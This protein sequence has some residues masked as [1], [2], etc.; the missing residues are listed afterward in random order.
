MKN[1]VFVTGHLTGGGSER[2]LT[3]IANSML[4]QGLEVSIITFEDINESYDNSCK[5]YKLEFSNDF[6]QIF[7][8]RKLIKK[9]KAEVVIAF[10]YYVAIKTVFATRGMECKVIVSERNDPNMLNSLLKKK[11]RNL[12]YLCADILVCQTDDAKKCFSKKTQNHTVVIP[13][14]IK[15]DLPVWG[16]SYSNKKII[17]FC[18]LEKQKNIPLL[19]RAF[20]EVHKKHPDY[21]LWIYGNGAEKENITQY[22]KEQ[23]LTE[24]INVYNFVDNIHDIAVSCSMFVSSSDYEGI[25]NSMLESMAMGLPVVCTDCPIGGAKMMIRDNENGLLVPCKQEKSLASAI[26]RIIE[27]PSIA[28]KLSSNAIKIRDDL[29]LENITNVWV[30]LFEEKN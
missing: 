14:P 22:I 3:L 30:S 4:K 15:K 25:S 8:L 26:C 29:S 5:V 27:N 17:N 1:I 20:K 21:S 6:N 12:A 16:G 2:V 11:M 23:Q 10:E 19:I 7:N 18:R 13:N 28:R 9:I 24:S